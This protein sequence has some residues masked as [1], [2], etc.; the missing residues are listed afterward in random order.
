MG[1]SCQHNSKHLASNPPA[2]STFLTSS[3]RA[4]R[5]TLVNALKVI[6]TDEHFKDATCGLIVYDFS[7]GTP[8]ILF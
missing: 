5:A 3:E 1:T 7:K 2:D 8:R 6:N 4:S